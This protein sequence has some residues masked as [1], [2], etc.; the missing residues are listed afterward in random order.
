LLFDFALK[1]TN[2]KV[3]ENKEEL[4]LNRTHQLLVCADDDNLWG[5]NIN[6]IM[7]NTEALSDTSKILGQDVNKENT[8]Y[9]HISHHQ[10]AGQN[11]NIKVVNRSLKNAAKFKYLGMM[12]TNKNH[13]NEEIKSRLHMGFAC[14][15]A[16]CLP[17]CHLKTKD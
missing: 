4:E 9:M 1:Y 3:Q 15:H 16:V 13:I 14:H 6:T 17:V 11:H 8:T 10:T 12:V 5:R 7:K 2:W